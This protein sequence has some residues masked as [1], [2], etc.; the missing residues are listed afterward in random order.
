M[1]KIL[2]VIAVLMFL[3]GTAYASDVPGWVTGGSVTFTTGGVVV[4]FNSVTRQVIMWNSSTTVDCYADF[5][6]RDANYKSG[7]VSS[8]TAVVLIPAAGKI[9]PNSVSLT[10]ATDNIGFKCNSG[11]G[12]VNFIAT[13]DRQ[14]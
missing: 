7:F 1:K 5:V 14:F 10:V 3:C 12:T 13:G 11:S 2:A 4:T 9:S 6:C 8:N